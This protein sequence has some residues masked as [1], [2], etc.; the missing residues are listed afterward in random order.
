MKNLIYFLSL[1]STVVF[2]QNYNYGIEERPKQTTPAKPAGVNNQLEEIEYFKAYLLPLSQKATIQKALD[3]YGSVRLE[4]GDYSGV[5]IVMKSN[6]KLYGHNTLNPVSRITIAAGSTNVHLESLNIDGAGQGIQFEAGNPITNCIIKTTK[7]GTI[8]AVG[9]KLEN[10]LFINILSRIHFDFS[11]T[12][13]YRNNKFIKQQS[14]IVSPIVLIKGNSIT[15]SNGNVHFWTNLLTPWGDGMVLDNLGDTTFIGVD[16]EGW[17]GTGS[18]VGNKAAIYARNMSNLKLAEVGGA[19]GYSPVKTPG[20]DIQANN[21]L[22]IHPAI[23]SDAISLV[24]PNANVVNVGAYMNYARSTG[25]VTGYDITAQRYHY[26]DNTQDVLY[27]GVVQSTITTP[28]TVSTIKN[29]FLGTKLTPW[30]KPNWETLPDPL[31]VNWKTERIGKPDSRDYIQNLINTK[32]I[33][34]LPEGVFYIGSTLN[35]SGQNQGIIGSGTGK[36]V[37]CGLTD[38]FPLITMVSFV[39]GINYHLSNL[40]LQGGSVGQFFPENYVGTAYLNTKFVVYR[41][42]KIGIH[43]YKMGGTD[44]CFFDN[45]S[46]VNCGVGIMQEPKMITDNVDI[47]GY[48]DKVVYYKGQYINCGIGTSNHA[49][50]GNNLNSWVDCKYDGNR[51]AYSNG[52]NNFSIMANCDFTNTTGEYVAKGGDLSLYGCNFYNNRPTIASTNFVNIYAEGCS[53]LDKVQFARVVPNNDNGAIVINS[54]IIG[55]VVTKNRS[56]NKKDNS[57]FINTALPFHPT[58]S[59]F[60]MKVTNGKPTVVIESEPNPYPQFLVT[61]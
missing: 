52:S 30:T 59:K 53:F 39:N 60:M 5:P 17:N 10:N 6:Q 61:Q 22:L 3:T 2:S 55:D 1:F 13:Y 33:A 7:Y 20:F 43:Y 16:A 24:S 41:D 47:S 56:D 38:D 51:I 29:A 49:M 34:E 21:L 40:T 36:T 57:L 48:I 14:G 45:I 28:A 15:P 12:G 8:T 27:N 18:S 37:I 4:K 58:L 50:R 11:A 31:G 46:F 54:T 25:T 26:P 32:G 9:A 19:N 42:Q 23:G 44:N 35:V